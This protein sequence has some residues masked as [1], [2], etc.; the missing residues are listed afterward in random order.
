VLEFLGLEEKVPYSESDLESAIVTHIEHFLLEFG[1]GF[2]FEAR[3]KRLTFDE[4]HQ[5]PGRLTLF[6]ARSTEGIGP[7]FWIRNRQSG[8][9][10]MRRRK[11]SFC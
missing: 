7:H 9:G 6:V 8:Q 2:L 3:Q 4:E 10:W 11:V 1:K 5:V